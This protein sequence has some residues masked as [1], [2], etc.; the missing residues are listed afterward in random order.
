VAAEVE[1]TKPKRK[2]VEK[3]AAEPVEVVE[4]VAVFAE[5][6]AEEDCIV[7]KEKK[8]RGFLDALFNTNLRKENIAK[9]EAIYLEK[10]RRR[11]I[12]R[13]IAFGIFTA[14]VTAII[15]LALLT[16]TIFTEDTWIFDV[17]RNI[18]D[19][20][21]GVPTREEIRNIP[22]PPAGG[23]YTE[24]V[25]VPERVVSPFARTFV[26]V[27]LG[28]IAITVAHF[29]ILQFGRGEG[30]RRK[31]I[32]TLI[33]SL[34]KYVGYLIVIMFLFDIWQLDPAI[35]AAIIAAL[36]VAIGFGAQGVISDLLTGLFLIFE[37]SLQVGDI[38]TVGSFRG[39]IEEIGIRTTRFMSVVGDVMIINNS[40]LKKFVNMSM[41][42]SVAI[43]DFTIE[44]R[45]DIEKVEELIRTKMEDIAE[46]YEVITDGPYYKGVVEFT[47]R[48]VMLRVVAKCE[49][50]ARLQLNRDLNR[51]FKTCLDENGIRMAVPKIQIVDK[52]EY[53]V[54]VDGSTG[55]P[56]K[57]RNP[58]QKRARVEK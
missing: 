24:T 55:L 15:V 52:T 25:L 56:P 35:L 12:K 16:E 46:R 4:P 34:T 57:K 54:D 26:V 47:D 17:A 58:V 51:E 11:R 28:F 21:R 50:T 1:E 33:A 8:R 6:Q 3:K 29:I 40:E 18:M 36:G 19:S 42:R 2:K 32:V 53:F 49:E 14:I 45:E 22:N 20:I 44:Y 30:K 48:G 13:I 39:E 31:T 7:E 41:H 38:I 10:K 27:S 5:E 9:N 43:C 37:N 23:P